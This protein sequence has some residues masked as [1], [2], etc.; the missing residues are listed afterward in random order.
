M[1][2]NPPVFFWFAPFLAFSIFGIVF[3][4]GNGFVA[5]RLGKSVVLWVVLSLIPGVN[6]IFLYYVA[7]AIVIGVLRRLN[8]IADKIGATPA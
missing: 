3:A 4:I 5:A 7:Y 8:A 2:P 6:V 1:Q